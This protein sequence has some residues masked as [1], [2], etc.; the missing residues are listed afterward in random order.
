MFCAKCSYV[1][2]NVHEPQPGV[3]DFTEQQDIEEFLRIANKLGLLVILRVGPY[4]CAEWEFVSWWAWRKDFSY[5][6]A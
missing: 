5:A 6:A 2:W 4:I 3:Y 1:A